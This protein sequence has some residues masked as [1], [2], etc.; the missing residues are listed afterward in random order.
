MHIHVYR[1]SGS[2]FASIR[3]IVSHHWC[4]FV[5]IVD[6]NVKMTLGMIWTIILRFA[7]QDISVDGRNGSIYWWKDVVTCFIYR[8]DCERWFAFMVSKEDSP[9]QKRECPKFPHKVD[10]QVVHLI[11]FI[12]PTAF[13]VAGKMVW[14]FVLLSIVIVRIYWITINYPK[15]IH[16]KIWILPLIL[17]KSILIFLAC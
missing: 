16:Y 7:I 14:P 9:L 1:I 5:E 6:G 8:N 17:P 15:P 13:H 12:L 10:R 11:H 2:F 3:T 4:F